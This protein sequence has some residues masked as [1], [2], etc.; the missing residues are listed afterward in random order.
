[1]ELTTQELVRYSRH[2]NLPNFGIEGQLKLKEASVLV[3]G[4]GGLGAPLLSYL[5][6]AGVGTIGVVDFDIVDESNLQRQILFNKEDIGLSKT[7]QAIRKLKLQNEHIHFVEHKVALNATNAMEIIS[8]YDIIADGTDNFPTRYLV[9][10]ACVLLNKPLIY[11]SIY[12]FEG[13]V[14][15]F[16]GMTQSG[17]GP[18]YRDLYPVPPPPG[19][20]PS[21]AEGGVLGVLPGIIG[22]IQALEV[23]K[24]I[25]NEGTPLI[26]KLFLF[27]ALSFQTRLLNVRRDPENPLNG[28]NPTIT[29]LIDYDQFCGILKHESTDE[30]SAN[31]LNLIIKQKL[32]ITLID[33]REPYEYEAGNIGGHLV[34][35]G[36]L[37]SAIDQFEKQTQIITICK[38]GIRSEKAAQLLKSHGYNNV[39]T[40]KGGLKSWK[41]QIDGD[42]VVV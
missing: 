13:Q 10:D 17:I 12:R 21:C 5:T 8:E 39:K 2:L 36:M 26:G 18:N 14:S 4:T 9:N 24:I 1:M 32:H 25:L 30:I 16:N 22:S 19:Q 3:V 31:D 33:V 11:G 35:L 29:A 42:L 37:D 34:P 40:L 7:T 15:V 38:S 41:L 28:K 20:V 6:A 27:D 23:I